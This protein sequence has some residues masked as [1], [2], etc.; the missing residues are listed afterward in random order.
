MMEVSGARGG[1]TQPCPATPR[2]TSL[3]PAPPQNLT[4]CIFKA[5]FLF[6]VAVN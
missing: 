6:D 3:T 1:A 5:V 4:A 2:E